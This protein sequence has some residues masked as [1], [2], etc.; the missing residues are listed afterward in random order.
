MPAKIH[1]VA[2]MARV[3][4]ATVSRVLNGHQDVG[5]DFRERVLAA[6]SELGYRPNRPARSLR[7]RAT[8]VLGVIISDITNPF[9]TAMVRG[10]E[11]TAQAGGYSVILANTDE[12]LA[13][14][15][16]YLEVAAAEQVAGVILAPASSTQTSI[17]V[18]AERQIPVI[19]VDRRLRNAQVDSVTVNNYRAA[20]EATRHLIEQ[21][22]QR[23][24]MIAGLSRTTTGSRRLAGYKAAFGDCGRAVDPS[25]IMHADFM[26]GGGYQAT[27]ALLD[28]SER[29]DGLFISNNMMT[30]GA[31]EALTEAGVDIPGEI[32]LV[33]FDETVWATALRPPLTVVAQPV[34]AIGESAAR[35]LLERIAGARSTPRN[36]GLH[37]SLIVRGSSQ[38]A[39]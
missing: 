28:R 14:E 29:P 31:L 2:A 6:V 9:F 32:A 1:D 30:V 19:L 37:A 34:Y 26:A 12:D 17:A 7:T 11:D 21:G 10:I 33:G 5:P 15:Q 4:P 16:R 22:C 27:K 39:G 3:S 24:G 23:V 18:L 38:R 35:L 13:K 36:I 25:L 8:T 20:R